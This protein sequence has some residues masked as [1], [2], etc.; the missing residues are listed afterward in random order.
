MT[1][2]RMIECSPPK[3]VHRGRQHFM[4]ER[5]TLIPAQP[6]PPEHR[7]VAQETIRTASSGSLEIPR[8]DGSMVVFRDPAP[9]TIGPNQCM[10]SKA[11]GAVV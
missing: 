8:A 3:A 4:H 2:L 10:P 1:P 6:V 7:V 11:N 9:L 5:Y